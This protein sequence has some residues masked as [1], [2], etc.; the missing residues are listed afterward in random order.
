MLIR[1]SAATLTQTEETGCRG[2]GGEHNDQT[3]MI[4]YFVNQQTALIYPTSLPHWFYSFLPN[5]FLKVAVC[6]EEDKI[7]IKA[8]S[9]TTDVASL[10]SRQ[11]G[12]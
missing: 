2:A 1:V 6:E 3:R 5:T 11:S 4:Q 9:E 10:I 7:M 8:V 12:A